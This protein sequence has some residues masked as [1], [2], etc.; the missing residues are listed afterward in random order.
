M[1]TVFWIIMAFIALNVVFVALLYRRRKLLDAAEKA[2]E[3]VPAPAP[4]IETSPS[5]E[6]PYNASIP[7]GA[8]IVS[9]RYRDPVTGR[10]VKRG[11][12]GAKR[13]LHYVNRRGEG[14]GREAIRRRKRATA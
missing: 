8:E 2:R 12:P 13:E 11:T 10:L 9:P 1:G 4:A 3:S 7:P 14:D 5:P 6:P